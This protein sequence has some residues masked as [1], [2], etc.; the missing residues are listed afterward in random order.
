[1]NTSKTTQKILYKLA[2]LAGLLPSVCLTVVYA[3]TEAGKS[4]ED[5]VNTICATCHVSGVAGAP[6]TDQREDWAARLEQGD[7]VLI[8]HAISGFNA[9]PARGGDMSLT[10]EEVRR[11]V[12]YMLA[13]VRS[14]D[15]AGDAVV[16]EENTATSQAD[17]AQ[18]EPKLVAQSETQQAQPAEQSTAPAVLQPEPTQADTKQQAKVA[19]VNT[20]NRLMKPASQRNPAPSKDGIHDP[21]ND[22]TNLLQPPAEAFDTLPKG[23]SGNYIDWVKAL[24]DG[25]IAPWFDLADA[26]A[27]PV[28]MDL[29]IIREV[30]G[31]MPDVVYPHKQHTE[32]LDCSNCH[33]A[34]F[35]PKKGD[36]QI[37]MA[38]ILLGEKC[39]VCH[40]KVAFPVSD[41]RRCHARKKDKI[42]TAEGE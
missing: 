33:P 28:I 17:V 41:C 9:M 23:Q 39:G 32:W 1:M 8:E 30:K 29:N 37:S 14:I 38:A 36:N 5:I 2:V 24:Q 35:T 18:P 15:S 11:A 31:S 27:Q 26:N 7:D 13:L 10:D 42:K 40:G 16:T 21:A 25:H 3:Q 6:K 20:F 12:V 4:G 34:I 19:A 22:A